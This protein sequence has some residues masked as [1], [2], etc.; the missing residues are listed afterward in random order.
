M[1]PL[2]LDPPIWLWVPE[3]SE[4]GLAHILTWDSVEDSVYWTCFMDSGVIL[5]LPNERVRAH[6]NGTL[7]RGGDLA[8]VGRSTAAEPG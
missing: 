4:A 8:R 2:Q 6:R 3:R 5:T 1:R 7:G